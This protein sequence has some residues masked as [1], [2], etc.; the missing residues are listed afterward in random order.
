MSTGRA[1]AALYIQP[2]TN[3][4]DVL[5]DEDSGDD[6]DFDLAHLTGHQL[7]AEAE[8]DSGS[9]TEVS[10]VFFISLKFLG[11]IIII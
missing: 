1:A 3:A 10:S 4:A 7:N 9:A 6:S 5:T 8:I 2:P 11:L